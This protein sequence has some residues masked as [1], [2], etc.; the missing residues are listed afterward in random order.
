MTTLHSHK[1]GLALGGTLAIVHF[2]WSAMVAVGWAQ[3]AINWVFR[4]HFIQPPYTITSFVWMY[5]L[6]LIVMTFVIGYVIGWV[7]AKVWNASQGD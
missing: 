4:L 1:T 3:P 5:A 6:G 7:F 2:F